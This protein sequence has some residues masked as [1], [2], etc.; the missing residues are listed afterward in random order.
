MFGVSKEWVEKRIHD[1]FDSLIREVTELIRTDTGLMKRISD[2]E[3][4][5]MVI[6]DYLKGVIDYLEITGEEVHVPDE[7]FKPEQRYIT[8][9]KFNKKGKNKIHREINNE[10]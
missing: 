4:E 2:L 7:T 3:S 9:T 8:V 6:K 5:N 1:F 10:K